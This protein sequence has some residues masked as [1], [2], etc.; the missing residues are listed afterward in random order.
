MS[1]NIS[2]HLIPLLKEMLP[3]YI[4]IID[5]G[6]AVARQTKAVLEKNNLLQ[7]TESKPRHMLYTNKETEVLQKLVNDP[8]AQV[9]Y[10]D[11]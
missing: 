7:L 1:C 5:S 8:G 3:N 4:T 10:L 2:L 11:F 9:A 6:E